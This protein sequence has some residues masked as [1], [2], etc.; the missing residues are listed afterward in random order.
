MTELKPSAIVG[1]DIGG[2]KL[3]LVAYEHVNGQLEECHRR[4]IATPGA[5]FVEL[6]RACT[7]LV[8][9]ADSEMGATCAV[10][11]G[12]PGVVDPV[13]GHQ[14]TSNVPALSG[15]QVK[16]ILQQALDRPVVTGND[17]HCFAMSEAHGGAADGQP[18][19]AGVIL[20]TGAGVGFCIGGRLVRGRT[21]M[22]GEWGHLQASTQLLTR[23]GLPVLP[24]GC[25]SVGCLERYVS[26]TGLQSI[27]HHLS[28]QHTS[29]KDI[30]DMAAGAG[31][32]ALQAKDS[33]RMHVDLLAQGLAQLV[34]LLDPD[35]LVLGGGLSKMPHLYTHLP[36]AMRT[37]M[38][39]GLKAP[40]ILQPRFGDAG[41]TRGAALLA[42]HRQPC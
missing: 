16:L 8:N 2:S 11:V 5:D 25:G 3:E 20:G 1:L 30:V 31:A 26:G 34:L 19:M 32:H 17:L 7:S 12:V 39:A 29:A 18:S 21:G 37:W 6:I 14:R 40:P 22:A 15:H 24:C 41:G 4:R 10:G 9:E 13:T 33:L 35:V 38:L 42:L 23:Y 27:F 36:L 28:G